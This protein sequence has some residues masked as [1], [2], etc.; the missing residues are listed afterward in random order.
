MVLLMNYYIYKNSLKLDFSEEPDNELYLILFNHI[1]QR[2][3][4]SGE[5]KQ[6]NFVIEKI[7]DILKFRNNGVSSINNKSSFNDLFGGYPL[8]QISIDKKNK[9]DEQ[10]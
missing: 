3:S 9:D 7:N 2:F 1:L 8:N 4:V 5:A 10:I 6:K